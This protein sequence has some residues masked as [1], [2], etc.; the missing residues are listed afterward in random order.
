MAVLM[1][2]GEPEYRLW[3]QGVPKSRQSSRFDSYRDSIRA[4]ARENFPA[5]LHG[6]FEIEVIFADKHR[7][8]PDADNVLK[9]ILDALRGIVYLDDSQVIFAKAR[10]VPVDDQLR[11]THDGTPHHTFIRL[12]DEDRFLIRIKQRPVVAFHREVMSS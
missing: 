7:T 8:R 10:L 4:A 6:R 2:D 12:L 3:I 11:T 5:P 9:P 1:I